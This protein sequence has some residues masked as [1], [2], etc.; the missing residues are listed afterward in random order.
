MFGALKDFE[1]VVEDII[2]VRIPERLVIVQDLN[3][4]RKI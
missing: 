3:H 2:K 1:P 4:D